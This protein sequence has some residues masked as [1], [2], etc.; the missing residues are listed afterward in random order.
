MRKYGVSISDEFRNQIY[1]MTEDE[2]RSKILQDRSKVEYYNR[3]M[4]DNIHTISISG[5]AAE[6]GITP[7]ELNHFLVS[8]S[9]CKRMGKSSI[10]IPSKQFMDEDMVITRKKD[11]I[12]ENGDPIT[13]DYIVGYTEKG[14]DYIV[15]LYKNQSVHTKPDTQ[16]RYANNIPYLHQQQPIIYNNYYNFYVAS[17][18]IIPQIMNNITEPQY[19]Q[20]NT[21]T[22]QL[23]NCPM[24][25]IDKDTRS[26]YPTY[27][28]Y[29]KAY[30]KKYKE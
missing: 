9:F 29:E 14:R 11:I 30:N 27:K 25:Y 24:E 22:N 8:M 5:I 19:Y 17:P 7:Q 18:D 13:T 1:N 26:K 28:D 6:L 10:Y 12:D 15:K 20:P 2:L 21:P 4:D 16:L 3:M 23:P